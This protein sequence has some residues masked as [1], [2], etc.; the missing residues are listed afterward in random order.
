M[1]SEKLNIKNGSLF[2]W[3]FQV[4]A[5]ALVMGSL[6][7]FSSN[8]ILAVV[9]LL[10]G[11]FMLTSYSGVL[12][13]HSEKSYKEYSSY[14]FIKVGETKHFDDVDKIFING[15]NVSQTVYTAHTLNSKTFKNMV[16]D[17]YLKF[18]N[19]EKVHLIS[20]KNKKKLMIQLEKASEYLSTEV[21]DNT[22]TE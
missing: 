17:G 2:P 19:G 5:A 12:I 21:Q 7:A 9:L 15:N 6:T 16:Y 3:H 13:D 8:I 20:S 18:T 4:V 11:V 10:I 14:L 1:A 22:L